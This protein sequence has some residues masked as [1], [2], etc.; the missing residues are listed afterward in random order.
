MVTLEDF[1]RRSSELKPKKE[2]R[3]GKERKRTTSHLEV[4]SAPAPGGV[5][6]VQ[7][8]LSKQEEE[9]EE[10]DSMFHL[11]SRKVPRVLSP[12]SSSE[13]G[14]SSTV[15]EP[16]SPLAVYERKRTKKRNLHPKTLNHRLY[17]AAI[18]THGHPDD[19]L[20]QPAGGALSRVPLRFV[21]GEEGAIDEERGDQRPRPQWTLVD[22]RKSTA[23]RTA[24]FCSR[25]TPA[26]RFALPA[27][28]VAKMS[29]VRLPMRWRLDV[30]ES[31]SPGQKSSRRRRNSQAGKQD[32]ETS[33]CRPLSFVSLEKAEEDYR[34][35]FSADK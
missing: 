13:F 21:P 33:E 1:L 22:P 10:E 8:E 29:A 30:P 27:G 12:E 4:D 19:S 20:V 14:A 23:I 24:R 3:Y 31:S 9:E 35:L 28:N 7:P 34:V 17:E 32:I 18:S 16:S 2:K 11:R 25:I 15:P 26:L 5:V 6:E